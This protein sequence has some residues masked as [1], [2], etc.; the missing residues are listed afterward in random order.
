MISDGRPDVS[1][2]TV[3][4]FACFVS[5]DAGDCCL[6]RMIFV[7]LMGLLLVFNDADAFFIF[8]GEIIMLP[9]VPAC[10]DVG[11]FTKTNFPLD[12]GFAILKVVVGG[13]GAGDGTSGFIVLSLVRI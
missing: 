5:S 8:A 1:F 9:D 11:L 12:V 13:G 4:A 10:V 2:D 7:N 3:N 6:V